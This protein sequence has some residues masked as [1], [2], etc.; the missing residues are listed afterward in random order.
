M[1]FVNWSLTCCLEVGRVNFS[2]CNFVCR[3]YSVVVEIGSRDV[4][5]EILILL[6]SNLTVLKT[7]MNKSVNSR[8][9]GNLKFSKNRQPMTQLHFD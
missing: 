8:W 7:M 3:D 5:K 9:H 2:K 4:G 6:N 1:T